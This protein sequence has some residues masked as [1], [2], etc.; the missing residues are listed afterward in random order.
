MI[1]E[2]LGIARG[3]GGRDVG[4]L[5]D[6]VLCLFIALESELLN[7]WRGQEVGV[8][9]GMGLRFVDWEEHFLNSLLGVTE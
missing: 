1:Q 5:Q 8:L 4:A 7:Q 3:R 9:R 6:A 2:E